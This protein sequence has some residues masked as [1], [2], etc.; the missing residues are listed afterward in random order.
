MPPGRTPLGS[1]DVLRSDLVELEEAETG[2][3]AYP[4][5]A[6]MCRTFRRYRA[7]KHDG[8]YEPVRV[9]FVNVQLPGQ[10]NLR[11]PGYP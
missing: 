8:P 10:V 4:R 6:F 1:A 3:T 7:Y 5:A 9:I 11:F 2:E